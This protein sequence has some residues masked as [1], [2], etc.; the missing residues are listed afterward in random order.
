MMI[1]RKNRRKKTKSATFVQSYSIK[2]ALYAH[3][4][5]TNETEQNEVT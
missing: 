1:K 5:N 4:S 2:C 3:A